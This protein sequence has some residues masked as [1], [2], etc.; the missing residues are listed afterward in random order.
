MKPGIL[1]AVQAQL[2]L[3]ALEFNRKYPGSIRR[4]L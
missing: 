4:R 2:K 1:T 3:A